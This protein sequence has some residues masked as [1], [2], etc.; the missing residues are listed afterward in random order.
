MGLKSLSYSGG[1]L[2]YLYRTIPYERV[3]QSG[4]LLVMGSLF[5]DKRGSYGTIVV[6]SYVYRWFNSMIIY[7]FT[8]SVRMYERVDVGR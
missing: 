2:F 7:L 3:T 1:S 8:L 4:T 6:L 5:V